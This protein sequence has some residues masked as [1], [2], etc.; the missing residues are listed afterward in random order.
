MSSFPSAPSTALPFELE[1]LMDPTS[2]LPTVLAPYPHT[3]DLPE[4]CPA[5]AVPLATHAVALEEGIS[6]AVT[7][8]RVL[9]HTLAAAKLRLQELSETVEARER[10]LGQL[11][12]ALTIAQL[13]QRHGSRPPRW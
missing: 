7:C 13:P 5:C 9:F 11:Q 12:R 2:A 3:L 10:H 4:S 1:P 6:L 8:Q